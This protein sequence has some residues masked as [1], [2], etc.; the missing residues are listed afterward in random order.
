MATPSDAHA[1]VKDRAA[2]STMNDDA[3]DA[4]SVDKVEIPKYR[5]DAII[6]IYGDVVAR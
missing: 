1:N 6:Y 2:S 3:T 5:M 4:C